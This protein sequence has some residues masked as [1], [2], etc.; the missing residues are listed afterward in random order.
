M[1]YHLPSSFALTD[2]L[3]PERLW[4]N[5]LLGDVV[6]YLWLSAALLDFCRGTRLAI[7]D[8]ADRAEA[9][10]MTDRIPGMH[11]LFRS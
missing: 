8:G 5:I 6:A 2:S 1:M 10:G 7:E 9:M 3:G 11:G 4:S